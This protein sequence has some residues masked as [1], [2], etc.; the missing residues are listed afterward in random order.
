MSS[1]IGNL[2]YNFLISFGVIVGASV[3]AGI[4]AIFNNDPPLKSM[5]NIA[6]SVKIWA[7]A[8]ALGGT[9]NSFEIIEKGIL[10]GEVKL[11]IKQVVFILIALLGANVGCSFIKLIQKCGQLW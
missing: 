7:V 10:K 4:A 5:F 3:F 8:I 1:F 2:I 6:D 9:F 11:I